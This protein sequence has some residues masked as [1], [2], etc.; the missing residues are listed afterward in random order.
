ME[1]TLVHAGGPAPL[2]A[3]VSYTYRFERAQPDTPHRLCLPA[4]RDLHDAL[5]HEEQGAFVSDA[6]SHVGVPHRRSTPFEFVFAN[7]HDA[8]RA[9]VAIAASLRTPWGLTFHV[10]D[11]VVTVETWRR[12]PA[13]LVRWP[14]LQ[15]PQD[16]P[17]DDEALVGLD[18][19][20][21]PVG[22]RLTSRWLDAP[23]LE[24]VRDAARAVSHST[25]EQP[26]ELV[27]TWSR[28]VCRGFLPG[29]LDDVATLKVRETG[30]TWHWYSHNY[31]VRAGEVERADTLEEVAKAAWPL[32]ATHPELALRV[33]AF[34][35]D[36]G[37]ERRLS[38]PV[39]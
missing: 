23:T 32:R 9:A 38:A 10:E 28:T 35:D 37:V 16:G 33:D 26:N 3:G 29:D 6:L 36:L 30:A 12:T 21:R 39:R 24:L 18:V 4:R 22:R 13:L 8:R 19:L 1:G 27:R 14:P 7:A 2:R 17:W 15:A 25:P 20:E 31:G 5:E 11:R 34:L